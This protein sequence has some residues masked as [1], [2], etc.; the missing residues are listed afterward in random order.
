QG[1]QVAYHDKFF[2]TL[3]LRG[4]V[5]LSNTVDP[6]GFGADLVLLHTDHATIDSSWMS[7]APLV[8]D[9]TYRRTDLPNYVAL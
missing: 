3:T 2:D 4:G 6:V 5:Q 1:A 7:S 9:A 8:L